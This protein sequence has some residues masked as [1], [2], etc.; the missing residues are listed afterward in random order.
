MASTSVILANTLAAIAGDC[1]K[2]LTEIIAE[3]TYYA[4]GHTDTVLLT[5]EQM[6]EG[7]DLYTTEGG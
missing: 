5:D 3:V 2:P 4:A 7:C 1:D 6:L